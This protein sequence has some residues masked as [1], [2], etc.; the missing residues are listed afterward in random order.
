ML[1]AIIL[2]SMSF[3]ARHA[4]ANSLIHIHL[5]LLSKLPQTLEV[6]AIPFSPGPLISHTKLSFLNSHYSFEAHVI[7]QYHAFLVNEY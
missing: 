1:N 6:A 7:Q 4:C 3:V 5:L 2:N